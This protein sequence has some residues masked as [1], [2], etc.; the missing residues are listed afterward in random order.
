M[1]GLRAMIVNDWLLWLLDLFSGT[2]KTPASV[3]TRAFDFSTEILET[4]R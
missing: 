4:I 3:D 1:N 2:R